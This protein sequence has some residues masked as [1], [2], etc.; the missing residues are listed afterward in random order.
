M[1]YKLSKYNIELNKDSEHVIIWN[2]RS[3]SIVKLEQKIFRLLQDRMFCA[4]ELHSHIMPLLKQGIIV[5]NEYDEFNHVC[6]NLK[7][8]QWATSCETLSL[9]IAPT[10]DCNFHCVYCFE[11]GLRDKYV[12][13]KATIERILSFVQNQFNINSTIKKLHV[14][15]FGGE[16]LLAYEEVILPLSNKLI[17]ACDSKNIFYEASLTTNGL[18]L[19]PEILSVLICELRINYFQI[20]MDGTEKIYNKYKQALDGEYKL[21][22]SNILALANYNSKQIGIAIRL[23]ANRTNIS[24][25]MM[26]VNEFKN[27]N[28]WSDRIRFYLGRIYSGDDTDF[29]TPE[30]EQK[31]DEFM[32]F[33]HYS[34]EY[35]RPRTI[36]CSQHSM[37]SVCIGPHG[38]LYKCEHYFG[39]K[40]MVIGNIDY[41]LDYS[42]PFLDFM[43]IPFNAKCRD[44]VIFP[45]CLGGCPQKRL[46]SKDNYFCEYSLNHLINKTIKKIQKLLNN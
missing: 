2:T 17:S 23:N 15:W 6:V 45:L 3:D 33:C 4:E 30:F 36:W 18:Y 24:D 44:C 16:P 13:D 38:E 29:S 8:E 40:Q 7:R 5:P 28:N 11:N 39:Q 10:L 14:S 41:G 27:S 9:I 31:T 42:K 34:D 43:E 37:S 25:L 21:V 46:Q 35:P 12:M 26:L 32:E 1:D 19:V 22:K 20:T